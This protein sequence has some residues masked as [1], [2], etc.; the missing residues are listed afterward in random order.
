[1]TLISCIISNNDE[2]GIIKKTI[3]GLQTD[4][5]TLENNLE[6]SYIKLN[7][8]IL[9]GSNSS[10]FAFLP[11]KTLTCVYKEIRITIL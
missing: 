8:R 1:M 9:Y 3:G 7:F 6:L 10:I 2:D 5:G 11:T 4:I